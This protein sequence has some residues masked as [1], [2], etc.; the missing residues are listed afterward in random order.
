MEVVQD[1]A[2]LLACLK[3]PTDDWCDLRAVAPL[4]RVLPAYTAFNDMTD[5][6]GELVN[7]LKGILA[8][9]RGELPEPEFAT[10]ADLIREAE[11]AVSR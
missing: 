8:F 2:A 10:V 11:G 1:N 5:G 4:A 9:C 3:S 7:A 6:W